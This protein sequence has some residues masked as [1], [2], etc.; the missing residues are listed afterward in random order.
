MQ[1]PRSPSPLPS[2]SACPPDR[3][4][5]NRKTLL[6]LVVMAPRWLASRLRGP[7]R[8]RRVVLHVGPH[9][10]GTTTLQA[11]LGGNAR[12]LAPYWSVMSRNDPL[13]DWLCLATRPCARPDQLPAALP[14][15]EARARAL[16]RSC[17]HLPRVLI[18][19]EDL[20][21]ARPTRRGEVGLY[22]TGAAKLASIVR[23]FHDG[24]AAVEVI[25]TDRPLPAWTASLQRDLQPDAARHVSPQAFAATHGFPDSWD[26]LIAQIRGAVAPAT[27]TV[28]PFAADTDHGQMGRAMLA[29][30]GVPAAVLDTVRWS[31]PRRQSAAQRQSESGADTGPDTE[32]N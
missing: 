28:L 22:P 11:T 30:L 10:T 3:A 17:R 16:A 7:A 5:M 2:P 4:V 29:H 32:V 15:I 14:E 12:L 19:H 23:A 25:F 8:E 26:G 20:L 31:S 1:P 18:S 24:G 6:R 21:G 9:K 27:V 13:A